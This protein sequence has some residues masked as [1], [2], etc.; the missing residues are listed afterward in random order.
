[1]SSSRPARDVPDPPPIT[2]ADRRR[3]L[4]EARLWREGVRESFD[5]LEDITPEDWRT[6]V[7]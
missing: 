5:A 7:R 1:M 4:E 6:V 2:E 3:I